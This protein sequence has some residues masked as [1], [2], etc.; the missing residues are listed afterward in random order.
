[1]EDNREKTVYDERNAL[2]Y[3]DFPTGQIRY[4]MRNDYM[5]K[6][7]LQKNRRALKGL[8]AALLFISVEEI[9]DIQVL[10]PI[11]LGESV[12]EKTCILDLE[13]ILNGSMILNIELQVAGF[14][15]WLERS[16]VYLCRAFNKL[17]AGENYGAVRPTYH[18]GILDFWLP[19]KEH[20]FYSEYLLINRR[21]GQIYSDKLGIRV[22]NLKAVEDDSIIK[23]PK[24]LYEWA[25]LFKVDTWE[26][27]KMLAQ[28]NEY[29][30]DTVVTLRQ[31]SEDEKIRMQCEAREMYEH[32]RASLIKQGYD[33][34][35][36]A[37]MTKGRA[38]GEITATQD[39]ILEL[40]EDVGE[41]SEDLEKKIRDERNVDTLKRWL[42]MAS[43]AESVDD[44]MQRVNN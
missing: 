1:M 16:L 36:I 4:T 23:E 2:L 9:V 41:I 17:P 18:I 28:E 15:Y 14:T 35:E 39:N 43:R 32:D 3:S 24:E 29:I 12:D 42:K 19:D 5:F 7:V 27:L 21:N 20:E 8:L 13:L 11:E 44:F 40:L 22:L 6:A 10:N 37:G 33:E 38:E 30:A 25:R 34:G 31:L 26:E